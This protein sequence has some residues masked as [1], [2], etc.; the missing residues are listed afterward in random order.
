MHEKYEAAFYDARLSLPS[1]SIKKSRDVMKA[2]KW[3]AERR[4]GGWIPRGVV[5]ISPPLIVKD[6]V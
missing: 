5:L 3:G 6:F 4:D 2:V 1:V